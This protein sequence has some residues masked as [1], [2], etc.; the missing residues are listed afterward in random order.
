MNTSTAP[1]FAFAESIGEAIGRG[2]ARG[3]NSGLVALTATAAPAAAAPVAP[4]VPARRRP[5][6]PPKVA[7]AEP[8]VSE[9]HQCKVEGCT[10]PTRSKG[11]CSKHYQAA[12]RQMKAK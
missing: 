8:E 6:R 10:A 2:I 5:G 11:L 4:E 3:I 12:R 1:S 9:E 7:Q